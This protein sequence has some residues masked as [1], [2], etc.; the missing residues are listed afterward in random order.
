[1]GRLTEALALIDKTI[2]LID[3][4]GETSFLAELLRLKAG[5]L[6]LST[7]RSSPGEAETC[8][9]Q[10]L[11]LSR[12]QRAR[13]WELRT[14]TDWAAL[15]AA[16][17][18]SESARTLL[19]PVFEQFEEGFDTDPMQARGAESVIWSVLTSPPAHWRHSD[20]SPDSKQPAARRT[21]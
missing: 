8:F 4:T 16:Q 7:P 1:M 21:P 19:R 12:R 20:G 11:E 5:L 17:G 3:A 6:L 2:Q 15:M 13:A 10:S 18:K 14:A 9:M